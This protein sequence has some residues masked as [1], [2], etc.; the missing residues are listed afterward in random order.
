[1]AIITKLRNGGQ[2]SMNFRSSIHSVTLS[3]IQKKYNCQQLIKFGTIHSLFTLCKKCKI[4]AADIGP[5]ERPNL[6]LWGKQSLAGHHHL[7]VSL[8]LVSAS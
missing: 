4:I 2:T 5:T 7:G 1:M 8:C 6:D 3:L